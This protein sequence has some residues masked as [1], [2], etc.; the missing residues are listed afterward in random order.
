MDF[1]DTPEEA[2]F[3]AEVRA[4]LDANAKLKVDADHRL[5]PMAGYRDDPASIAE[6]RRW[7]A[8]L[9]DAGWA[10]IH[11][12]AAHGGRD[13]T[14]LQTTVLAEELARY[15]VP[16]TLFAIGLAMIGPTLIAHGTD[17][18]KA[19]HLEPMR[20]GEEIWCQLW[21]EP[22]A[23]SDLASL[24]TRAELDGD[25]YVLHGQ[26]VWTSGAHYCDFGLGIFRTDP[27]VPKHKGISCLIVDLRTPGITIRPL[28]QITGAAHF[29]E[30]FFDGARVPVANLVGDAGDGWRVARTT[31][32]NERH[33][34]GS[35]GSVAAS[36][37]ALAALAAAT[38]TAADP[39]VR[40]RL[41]RVFT[42]G[43]IFDLTNAR[44]R[45]SMARGEIPGV[46]GSILK[47]AIAAH[48]TAVAELGTSLLGAAGAL[49]G[50]G[51]P[52][53]GRWPDALLGSFAMHIGG[54]TDEVQ[55]NIVGELVLGLPREPDPSREVPF[56]ELRAGAGPGA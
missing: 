46:E 26:K 28:R 39:L 49:V 43:R 19:R 34:T 20:R 41:A 16:D 50:D 53:D 42:L 14:A 44:V 35:L 32:M 54:G 15:D 22:D 47:L 36:F 40:Q 13:A 25:E 48:G 55:R 23:G 3:R 52:E 7:Q 27:S 33:A 18:Q 2:A 1:D 38:G 6:A 30:V 12:P 56:R 21:S 11:W 4:W 31:L 8:T 24:A 5:S 10:A 37:D 9:A 29:N 17:E 51:A 45:T